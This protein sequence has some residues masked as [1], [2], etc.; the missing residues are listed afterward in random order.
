[1]SANLDLLSAVTARTATVPVLKIDAV[2]PSAPAPGGNN[3][4]VSGQSLPPVP[5]PRVVDV[6]RAVQKL[7]ELASGKERS[8]QFQVDEIS[9]RTVITV[10]NSTTNQ[11]VRQIPSEELLAVARNLEQLGSLMDTWI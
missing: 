1:M 6:Q 3:V 11:V 7:S 5:P 4:A 9:G 2:A 10:I 8:L